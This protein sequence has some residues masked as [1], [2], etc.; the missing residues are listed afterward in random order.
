MHHP[1][2]LF[3]QAVE[4]V[5]VDAANF[6]I[7]KEHI[8]CAAHEIPIEKK[9]EEFFGDAMAKGVNSLAKEGDLHLLSVSC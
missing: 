8:V 1:H 7:L 9:D 6:Q 4:S 2:Q 5:Q 3:S